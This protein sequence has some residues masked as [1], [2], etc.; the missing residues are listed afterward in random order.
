MMF[1][2]SIILFGSSLIQT[3]AQEDVSELSCGHLYYRTM[4]LDE[5]QVS[6]FG[7]KKPLKEKRK[8]KSQ[9]LVF[10]F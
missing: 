2:I 3:F 10:A 4:Y 5:K 9:T 6:A 1:G 8:N 7:F